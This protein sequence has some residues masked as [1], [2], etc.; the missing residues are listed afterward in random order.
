MQRL[1]TSIVLVTMSLV[2]VTILVAVVTILIAA[3]TI[4]IFSTW[5]ADSIK[6]WKGSGVI[7]STQPYLDFS[8]F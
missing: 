5:F 8:Q 2:T 1:Q 7:I 4:E 3:V 6:L